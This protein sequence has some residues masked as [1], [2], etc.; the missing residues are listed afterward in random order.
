MNISVD[1]VM[2]VVNVVFLLNFMEILLFFVWVLVRIGGVDIFGVLW[3]VLLF[4]DGFG[5]GGGWYGFC[6]CLCFRCV[7][8]CEVS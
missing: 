2:S 6:C 8:G 4:L 1:V 5:W 7:V 3:I